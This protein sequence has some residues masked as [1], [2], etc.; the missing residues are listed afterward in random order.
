MQLGLFGEIP[1]PVVAAWGGGVDSTAMLIEMISRRERIDLVLFA[2]TGSEKPG[3]YTFVDFFRQWMADRGIRSEVVRYEAKN[4]KH[5][6]AYRSLHENV[7]TNSTLPSQ[8]LGGGSCSIKW[9]QQPQHA[10]LKA[11][12]PS[13]ECWAA[14][15]KVVKLIGY[16]CSPADQ[17]RWAAQSDKE[18]PHYSFRFPLREWG[19]VRA[20]C[21]ERIRAEG[22]PVPPKSACF[23]CGASKPHEIHDLPVGQLRLIV[24]IEARAEPRLRN[25]D[26]LWRKPVLG[27]RGATPRPGSMT[28]YIL[29]QKLLPSDEID[30]IRALAP[31]SLTRFQ[32][33]AS[34]EAIGERPELSEWL[35]LFEMRD[36][37]AFDVEGAPR[38]YTAVDRPAPVATE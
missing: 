6:P 29:E 14:G 8:S 26:G 31:A 9:K 13:R 22:I 2:D 3:T 25:C 23:M 18:D 33:A 36:R 34:S 10:F 35:R 37:G 19:W 30:E 38:F 5:W 12:G 15:G 28:Q 27:F 21:E 32:E 7:I 1:V 17:R 16:D 11:W 20:Q 4:F 24:L